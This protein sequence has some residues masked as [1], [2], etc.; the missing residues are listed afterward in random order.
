MNLSAADELEGLMVGRP[1]QFQA[2]LNR[3]RKSIAQGKGLSA[4]AF[5]TAVRKRAQERRVGA[6]KG[7]QS[8]R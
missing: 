4:D 5:W 8:E 2:L 1:S 3:S 7:R 6:P